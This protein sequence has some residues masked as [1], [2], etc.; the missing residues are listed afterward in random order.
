[1]YTRNDEALPDPDQKD[2]KPS[3]S[4]RVV[5]KEPIIKRAPYKKL[6]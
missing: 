1:M 6:N 4:K 5:T 2:L 3:H